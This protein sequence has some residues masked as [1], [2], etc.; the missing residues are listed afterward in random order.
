MNERLAAP[1]M[2]PNPPGKPSV[3]TTATATFIVIGLALVMLV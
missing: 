3:A 1:K 2:T